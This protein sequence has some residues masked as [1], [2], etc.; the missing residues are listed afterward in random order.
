M[1]NKFIKKG[2]EILFSQQSSI[3]SAA[4]LIMI[5]IVTSRVLG[6]VRQRLL[7]HFFMADELS[8]F[9]AAFRL[10]DLVFEVL[11]FGTFSSAFI[12]VFARLVK[13]E[14]KDAWGVAASVVNIG[15][16][17]FVILG[18]IF[19]LFA[20]Q[21]YNVIAPGFS[22][23]GLKQI[24][25][26]TRILF[27]AQIFFVISYVLTGVLESLRRFLVPA[28]APIFYNLGIILGTIL[29]SNQMGLLGPAIGVVIGAFSHFL[30]QLPLAL[31]LGFR[32]KREIV[33]TDD[34][35]KIGK[36]AL[37]RVVEV[38]FL[39]LSKMAE[40]Y[41]ASLLTTASY[42]YYTF[43]NTLQL[44]PVGLFGVSIAKAAL[45]TLAS[46]SD[47][48]KLFAKTL[49]KSLGE[50]VFLVAPLATILVVLRIPI[51]R[52]TFGTDIFTW[53]ATVQ[54]SLVLSSFALGIVFQAINLLLARAFYALHETKIP[55]MSSLVSIFL[56][57][58]LDFVFIKILN[59]PVWGLALSFSIGNIVQSIILFYLL[60]RRLNGK[61]MVNLVIPLLKITTAAVTSGSVMFFML[62]FFDR[63]TWVKRLTFLSKID[64]INFQKF[65]L[66]TRYTVNLFV[67]TLFV[68]LFGLSVYILV[69][70]ILKSQEVWT[71]FNLLQRIFVK[72]V[73]GKV[74]AKEQ[75]SV[76]PPTTDTT[77]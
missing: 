70:V 52:L 7:A 59:Y 75:E 6:L 3:L 12:P 68:S 20:H 40:L 66:D 73:L 43:A 27:S 22:G 55:V 34:V 38:S 4:T 30:I 64:G 76:T 48:E 10:P 32:F 47:D 39:Q 62:R 29:F 28:L 44:L 35:K 17:A 69:S 60:G 24:V 77:V 25:M 46:S 41:F 23:E 8:L 31:K 67:L 42:T 18:L 61:K 51:I 26:L 71:F 54:T 50:M 74:P 9:F 1:V 65:V 58:V 16:I 63:Y 49:W 19:C 13:K 36:L 37:P 21:I 14:D 33:I 45:P 53:E 2:R 5:M 72:R 56:I 11:V 57:I 15:L